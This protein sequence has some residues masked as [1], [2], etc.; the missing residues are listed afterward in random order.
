VL[1]RPGNRT[2][3]SLSIFIGSEKRFFRRYACGS[4]RHGR[5][6]CSVKDAVSKIKRLP[7]ARYGPPLKPVNLALFL[8]A[9]LDEVS[10]LLPTL[11]A[12]LDIEVVTVSPL[13]GLSALP[14]GLSDSHFS[15]A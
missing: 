2:G 12:N 10:N 3:K 1:Q 5:I 8:F 6:T 15:S 7:A 14:A 13:G 4:C 11:V 9:P